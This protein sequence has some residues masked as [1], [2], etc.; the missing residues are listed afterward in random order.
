MS[1]S[2]NDK[3]SIH[4]IEKTCFHKIY[5]IGTVVSFRE[6]RL[7]EAINDPH[8]CDKILQYNMHKERSGSLRFAKG[9]SETFQTL[10]G[11]V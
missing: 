10:H 4:F 9:M 1:I 7:I 6:L 5:I 11:L 3:V 8:I 2:F